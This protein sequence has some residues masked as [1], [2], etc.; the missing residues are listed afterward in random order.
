MSIRI[1]ESNFVQIITYPKEQG[2]IRD[3]E[4]HEGL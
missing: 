2:E 4:T 1:Q 3:L